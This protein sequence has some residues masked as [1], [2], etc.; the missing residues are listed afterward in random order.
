V[1]EIPRE[2]VQPTT[3]LSSQ[4]VADRPGT[5]V[6]H[7]EIR[8]PETSAGKQRPGGV[9]DPP[10]DLSGAKRLANATVGSMRLPTRRSPASDV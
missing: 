1:F 4:R 6:E 5:A 2:R 10:N 3:V 8:A 7:R 9:V